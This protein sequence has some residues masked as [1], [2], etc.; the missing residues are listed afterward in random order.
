LR[1]SAATPK[2]RRAIAEA[3]T[4][5]NANQKNKIKIKKT[6]KPTGSRHHR[7][8]SEEHPNQGLSTRAATKTALA[9]IKPQM[10]P[11][12]FMYCKERQA[13]FTA[14]DISFDAVLTD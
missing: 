2:E 3:E 14:Q 5:K 8:H 1:V 12:N 6:L 9:T 7:I 13:H 4:R 11:L 10:A